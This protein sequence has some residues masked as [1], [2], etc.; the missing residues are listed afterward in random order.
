[1]RRG[2]FLRSRR[3]VG[4]DDHHIPRTDHAEILTSQAFEGQR[5]VGDQPGALLQNPDALLGFGDAA[6]QLRLVGVGG[7]EIAVAL[8]SGRRQEDQQADDAD[9]EK[10]TVGIAGWSCV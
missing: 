2:R 6:I 9:S 8:D 3:L 10:G 1:M 4:K 5:V 7:G